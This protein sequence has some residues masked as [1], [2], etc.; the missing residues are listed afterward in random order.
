MAG[1]GIHVRRKNP[2]LGW[3]VLIFV[4]VGTHKHPFDRLVK[5]IDELVRD[6]KIRENVVMQ[7]G[8]SV[9]EPKNCGFFKF[10]GAEKFDSLY[11]EA[12]T[13][14]CHAGAGSIINA[15]KNKKHLV[16]VP[17][18]RK[19]GEHNDDHQLDLAEAMEN[20]GKAVCVRDVDKI[21]D[22][23][24]A[25]KMQVAQGQSDRLENKIGDYLESLAAM[26]RH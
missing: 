7:T 15:M 11:R 4:T 24:N 21:P 17:R 16:I 8:N 23:I 3:C 14:I 19:F 18:L 25:A 1:H 2:V 10:V 12:D 22:A 5:K 13:I 20:D 26:K 9:Y 6:G